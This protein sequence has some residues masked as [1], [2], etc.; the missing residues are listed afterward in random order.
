MLDPPTACAWRKPVASNNVG[1]I[2]IWYVFQGRHAFSS[3][4]TIRL[5]VYLSFY[6]RLW[7]DSSQKSFQAISTCPRWRQPHDVPAQPQVLSCGWPQGRAC[8]KEIRGT[9]A[10]VRFTCPLLRKLKNYSI[11]KARNCTWHL[12]VVLSGILCKQVW[13]IEQQ[14]RTGGVGEPGWLA[15]LPGWQTDYTNLLLFGV[16]DTV[17]LLG[18]QKGTTTHT[19]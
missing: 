18:L 8:E 19:Q 4:A 16:T 10:T 5:S 14:L 17:W 13:V 2:I 9:C 15:V 7:L 11:R 12:E 1:Y 6:A 3:G